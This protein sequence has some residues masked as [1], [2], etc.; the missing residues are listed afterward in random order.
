[1][2]VLASTSKKRGAWLDWLDRCRD[3]VFVNTL[4]FGKTIGG[5]PDP[6]ADAIVALEM[7]LRAGGYTPR[8][9][10]AYNFRGI[11]G[12]PCSCSNFGR[13]SLHGQGIAIDIDPKLN[14]FLV[15]KVFRW[16]D[17]A[18]TPEQIAF[19]E[20]IRNTKGEQLWFWAGRWKSIKDYMHFEANVDPGST[21]VD[22]TTVPDK[23]DEETMIRAAMQA[24]AP[25]YYE[26]LQGVTTYPKGNNPGYWG[27]TGLPGG[28]ADDEWDNP[29]DDFPTVLDELYTASISAGA[30][31][32]PSVGS[33]PDYYTK[34]QSDD[35]FV[36]IGEGVKIVK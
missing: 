29:T 20:G 1:M 26:W 18:F 7:A 12:A 5:V 27:K 4:F 30:L 34:G 14:P 33:P 19:V 21:D 17:T 8:S 28:P 24:Q 13:C 31:V 9:A 11:G 36:N 3:G 22:W 25:A 2:A 16:S 23:E 15:T 35:R 32:Q 6:W 10:W